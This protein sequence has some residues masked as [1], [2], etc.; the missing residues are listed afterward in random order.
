[1]AYLSRAELSSKLSEVYH[2]G[3]HLLMLP[4]MDAYGLSISHQG[5]KP[6]YWY[7]RCLF[8][9]LATS[10]RETFH[11][12]DYIKLTSGELALIQQIYTHAFKYEGIRRLFVWCLF[13][14][15]LFIWCQFIRAVSYRD[16]ILQLDVYKTTM[17]D[18][19]IP[20]TSLCDEKVYI[21]PVAGRYNNDNSNV[22][23][24]FHGP[25]LLHCNWK[26]NFF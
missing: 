6:L 8:T 20:L 25:D 9:S 13:V 15:C 22:D 5:K 19:I 10:K 4:A 12:G 14:W 21:I 1:M 17:T 23:D 2:P 26:I 16:E 18:K 11:I 7:E 3:F 24:N